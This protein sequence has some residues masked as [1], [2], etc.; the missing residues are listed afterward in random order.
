MALSGKFPLLFWL[1]YSAW[2]ALE[3]WVFSRD[4]RAVAGEKRDRGSLYALIAALIIGIWMAFSAPHL[5]PFARIPL[6]RLL[7]IRCGVVLMWLGIA[8]RLWAI[9]TLGRFFRTSV[10]VLD[11]H[12]LITTGPYRLLR[13]P[14]YSGTLLTLAGIGM[15]MDNWISLLGILLG[16]LIGYGWRIRVEERALRQRFGAS[17]DQN[18][19]RTWAILPFVW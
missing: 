3:I 7:M 19:E 5:A 9:L 16:G 2:C 17:F 12:R 4:R 14:A 13:H 6:S 8:L 10:F 18:C 11:E 1:S 15:A